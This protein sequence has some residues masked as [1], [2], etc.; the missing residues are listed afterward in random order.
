MALCWFKNP[1]D[2]N[3]Q[4]ITLSVTTEYNI[5]L[6]AKSTKYKIEDGTTVSDHV[7][8]GQKKISFSGVLGRKPSNP[9]NAT[10]PDKANPD[11]PFDEYL[12]LIASI[13]ESG[14]PFTLYVDDNS[15][16]VPYTN[17]TLSGVE[18]SKDSSVSDGANV[19][20]SVEQLRFGSRAELKTI[21]LPKDSKS[22]DQM[23]Q[24]L[25]KMLNPTTLSIESQLEKQKSL[26]AEK[27]AIRD[28]QSPDNTPV[29]TVPTTPT[30]SSL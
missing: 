16:L 17:C 26:R 21:T 3:D 29:S 2:D 1:I 8:M 20:V 9:I 14:K 22:A 18:A 4:I 30:N 24:T 27:D 23:R 10:D 28:S 7:T 12:S 25:D 11:I 13:M 5:S 15:S 19:K 6:S